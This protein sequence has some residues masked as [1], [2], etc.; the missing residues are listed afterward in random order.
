MQ[1]TETET[2]GGRIAR[3]R[4]ARGVTRS[5]LARRMGT[6]RIQV[7]RA[8]EDKAD[9]S[10]VTIHRIAEALDVEVCWLLDGRRRRR[11]WT[12]DG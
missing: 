12:P 8:E 1:A 10:V 11:R 3:A 6:S 2:V 7:W 4:E 9:V 5:E